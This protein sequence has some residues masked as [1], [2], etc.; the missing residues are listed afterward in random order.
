MGTY[1]Q[2]GHDSENLL[3]LPELASYCG[4]ILSPVN[5]RQDK[6]I[7][8]IR[9]RSADQTFETVF[10]PQLYYPRTQTRDPPRV[11]IFP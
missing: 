6:V 1:H 3:G 5:Y 9:G 8:Q 4:A 10:D 7:A 11:D 2:M